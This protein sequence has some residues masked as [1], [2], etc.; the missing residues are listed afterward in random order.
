MAW[1]TLLR[2]RAIENLSYVIGVNRVG[3]DGN[4]HSYCGDSSVI[5]PD[6]EI[7]F[8]ERYREIIETVTLKRDVLETYRKNFP[9][10]LDADEFEIKF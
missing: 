7:V 6:G 5:Q 3:N 1:N 9:A 2:A 10:Y 4:G 8:T